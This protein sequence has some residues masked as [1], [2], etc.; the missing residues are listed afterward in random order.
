MTKIP[1]VNFGLNESLRYDAEAINQQ[2]EFEPKALKMLVRL[3]FLLVAL[4][5]ANVFSQAVEKSKA[6][7]AESTKPVRDFVSV[8]SESPISIGTTLKIQSKIMSGERELNIWLP[9]SYSDRDS[10]KQF[11]VLYVIDGGAEQDFQHISGLSQLASINGHFHSMIVVGIKT[12]NRIDELT[13]KPKDSRYIR[14]P[15]RGGKS[16]QFMDYISEEVIPLVEKRYR[17]TERRGVLGE[18]LAGL[19]IAEVFMRRPNMFSDY[20]SVSPSLWWD[21]RALAKESAALIAKHDG[22]SRKL[23]LTM[24]N[25]GG[26]MQSGLDMLM[27]SIQDNKPAG[28]DWQYVDRRDEETHS[29]IYHGAAHDALRKLFGIPA[30]EY[31]GQKPWYLIEGGQPEPQ[32]TPKDSKTDDSKINQ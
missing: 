11:H 22:K 10:T 13:S 31:T 32:P 9:P 21:D 26:T 17:T 30:I 27:Q 12:Q 15:A 20:I 3:I 24:A 2:N 23:Y 8:T 16:E 7:Q 6:T 1:A 18:S 29:T 28:L 4:S 5:T 19:F 25:E 14:V